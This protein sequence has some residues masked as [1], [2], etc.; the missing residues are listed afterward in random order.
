MLTDLELSR[1][2]PASALRKTPF[3]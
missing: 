2:T 1:V 3:F